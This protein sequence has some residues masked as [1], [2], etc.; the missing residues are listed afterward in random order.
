MAEQ[1]YGAIYAQ[2]IA[3][4]GL[5][6]EVLPD[7]TYPVKIG[8]IK[9]DASKN[10]KFRVGIRL[11]VEDGPHNGKSTWVN[12]TFSPE[13]PKA[14]AIF[15]RLMKELGG[16]PVEAAIAAALSPAEICAYITVGATG[17]A[18][19][20]H[21]AYG[22]NDDGSERKFQDLKKFTLTAGPAAVPGPVA[23][24]PAAAP[25]APVAAPAPVLAPAPAEAPVAAPVAAPAAAPGQPGYEPF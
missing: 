21:H 11:Q 4:S 7:D 9:P 12:Q 22:T 19:L 1:N 18:Q 14:V 13:N 10:G 5:G 20:G 3:E 6:S 23:Q 24:V 16:Q 25:V 8:T 2:A 17:L 15:L